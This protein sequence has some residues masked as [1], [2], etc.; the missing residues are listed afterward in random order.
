MD[1]FAV[2]AGEYTHHKAKFCEARLTC[3]VHR[4]KILR[5]NAILVVQGKGMDIIL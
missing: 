4:G 3:A 5:I 2:A 1:I